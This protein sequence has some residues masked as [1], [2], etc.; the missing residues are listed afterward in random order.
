MIIEPIGKP[1]PTFGVRVTP[2]KKITYAPNCYLEKDCAEY[3][4]R[5]ITIT[6]NYI[7]D[8]LCSKLFYVKNKAGEWLGSTLKYIENGTKKVLRSKNK[9]LNG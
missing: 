8:K 2:T 4:G 7:N 9:C 3:K 5:K 1:Q 6:K